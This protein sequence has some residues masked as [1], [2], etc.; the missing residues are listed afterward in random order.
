MVEHNHLLRT[1]R[2]AHSSALASGEHLSR[3]EL[4][5]AVNAWLWHPTGHR[6]DLDGHHVAKYERG[7]VGYPIAPYRAALRAVL[8]VDADEALGFTP[9]RQ[10]P[11]L[12]SATWSRTGILDRAEATTR[13]DLINRR[14]LLATGAALTGATLLADVEPWLCP[15][16]TDI[17]TRT[18]TFAHAE[19]SAPEHV[20]QA[21]RGWRCAGSGLSRSAVIDRQRPGRLGRKLGDWHREAAPYATVA[22]VRDTRAEIRDLIRT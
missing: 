21:F 15:L 16:A 1:A 6:Y 19:V 22:A 2:K 5:E 18:G 11:T 9:P 7:V 13:S 20:A 8:G 10:A 3:A 12:A 4:A 14:G 17:T